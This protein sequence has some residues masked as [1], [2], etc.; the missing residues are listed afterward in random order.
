MNKQQG[1][2]KI[3]CVEEN[4]FWKFC[5][6]DNGPGIERK[7]FE[8][9][10]QIFQTLSPRDEIESTGIG[11]TVVKKIIELYGG[12]IWLESKPGK[13]SIFFFTLPKQEVEVENAKP[14]TSTIS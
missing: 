2:V 11:L 6:A 12:R 3:G 13:G 7:Y 4:S 1:Q 8:K 9:V 10:F 14:Q 5:V